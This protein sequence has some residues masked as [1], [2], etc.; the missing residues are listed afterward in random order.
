MINSKVTQTPP[1][2]R[3][4]VPPFPALYRGMST[5]IWLVNTDGTAVCVVAG[6]GFVV[7]RVLTLG[8]ALTGLK[9][10]GVNEQVTLT[11]ED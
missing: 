9:R 10:L 7:G 6:D 2:P 5:A 8:T 11:N 4:L 3:Q 1:I